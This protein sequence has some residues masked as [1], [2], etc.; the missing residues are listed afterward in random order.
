MLFAACCAI[1]LFSSVRVWILLV[2]VLSVHQAPWPFSRPHEIPCGRGT[3][4]GSG[5][6]GRREKK[7]THQDVLLSYK[8]KHVYEYSYIRIA[9]RIYFH[10]Y[11]N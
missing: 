2:A 8:Y 6:A 1:S 7:C 9:F 4:R 5:E 3:E 11:T 10:I